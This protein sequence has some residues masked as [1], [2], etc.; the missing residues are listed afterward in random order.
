MPN[1][2][3]STRNHHNAQTIIFDGYSNC[4][5]VK[6]PKDKYDRN[7]VYAALRCASC[8]A[9]KFH[10]GSYTSG[11][12]KAGIKMSKLRWKKHWSQK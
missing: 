6:T 4:F 9:L 12:L 8:G 7:Y 10:V 5:D 3:G 11:W 1:I 2:C